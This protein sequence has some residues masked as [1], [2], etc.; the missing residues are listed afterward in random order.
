MKL[1]I[2][3]TF[4]LV[5]PPDE[6]GEQ[7]VSSGTILADGKDV[8]ISTQN[9]EVFQAGKS[10][11]AA[12]AKPFAEELAKRGFTVTVIGPNG[13]IVSVGAVKSS[14]AQRLFSRSRYIRLGS[15]R[16]LMP[17]LRRQKPGAA[18]VP[19]PPGTPWPLI[20][21]VN[22]KIRRNVTTTHY[23]S[24]AGRPR[25]ILVRDSETWDGSMPTEF[26][27]TGPQITIGSAESSDLRLDGLDELHAEIVHTDNDE[28]KLVSHGTTGGSTDGREEGGYTLRT[29]SRLVMGPWRLGFF[30]EEYA[31]HGR[32]FGGRNGGEFAYQKPQYNPSTQRM[33]SDETVGFGDPER[34]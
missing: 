17:F 16:A 2:D 23:G 8:E 32:P 21:T 18:A 19:F 30:R 22:R 9:P 4:E 12:A 11:L 29:G 20:P 15:A 34:R 24:G 1:H 28:Y 31:D 26:N 25:L 5:E 7:R 14:A 3:M 13:M 27:L 10:P 6:S 33:E